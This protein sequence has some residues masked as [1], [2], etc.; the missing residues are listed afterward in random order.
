[1]ETLIQIARTS[2]RT[3]LSMENADILTDIVVDAVLAI[4]ESGKPTDLNMVEIMEMQ[5]RTEA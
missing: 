4:N 3:K 5:H 1:R 2:L